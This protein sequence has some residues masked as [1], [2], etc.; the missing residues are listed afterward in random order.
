MH[1]LQGARAVINRQTV[2]YAQI[3]ENQERQPERVVT[4]DCVPRASSARVV[5]TNHVHDI[6]SY[7][8]WYTP[9]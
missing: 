9:V 2:P 4:T 5:R 7:D 6:L 1:A 3:L 8:D